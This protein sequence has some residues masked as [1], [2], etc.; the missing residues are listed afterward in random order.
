V[1]TGESFAAV[2]R[3]EDQEEVLSNRVRVMPLGDSITLGYGDEDSGGYRGPLCQMLADA[4]L[5]VDFVGS[6]SDGAIDDPAH[7][8]HSGSSA[9]EIQEQVYDWLTANPADIVLLHIGTN[10]ITVEET[11]AQITSQIAQI[12]D[13]IDRYESS[14][15]TPVT[16]ILARIINRGDPLEP[17][18]VETTMLNRS[19]ASMAAARIETG[20]RLVVADFE[21]ALSYP[22]DLYLDDFPVHPNASGY[23]KM[24]G[25]WFAALAAELRVRST[26]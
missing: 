4:G 13:E 17:L 9:G 2:V 3:L 24:A 7:E 19:I 16:V 10:N 26:L 1:R 12:L 11:A 5:A 8:G 15:H 25:V 21:P 20:D 22:A 6:Q 14:S 18:G 23:R